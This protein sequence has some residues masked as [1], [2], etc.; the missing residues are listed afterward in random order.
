LFLRLLQP[1]MRALFVRAARQPFE[2]GQALTGVTT[3]AARSRSASGTNAT[4][5]RCAAL[6]PAHPPQRP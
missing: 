1:A 3:A 5:S 2:P 6:K 4:Q